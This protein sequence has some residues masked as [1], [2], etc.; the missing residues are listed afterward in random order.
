MRSHQVVVFDSRGL[1]QAREVFKLSKLA[2]VMVIVSFLAIHSIKDDQ[3][4]AMT[5]HANILKVIPI[6]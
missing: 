6:T 2:L 3:M 4:D 5:N 1:R